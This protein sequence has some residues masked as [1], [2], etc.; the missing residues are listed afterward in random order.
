MVE[1]RDSEDRQKKQNT[2]GKSFRIYAQDMK[3]E[4][5]EEQRM[6]QYLGK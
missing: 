5:K 4:D 2:S 1:D 3:N 6:S